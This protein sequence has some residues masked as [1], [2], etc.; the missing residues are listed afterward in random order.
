MASQSSPDQKEGR[1]GK[2]T[3]KLLDPHR[4]IP[5]VVGGILS[6]LVLVLPPVGNPQLHLG[7]KAAVKVITAVSVF[8]VTALL[9]SERRTALRVIMRSVILGLALVVLISAGTWFSATRSAF[10]LHREVSVWPKT[11]DERFLQERTLTTGGTNTNGSGNATTGG[12][13]LTI[14]LRSTHV[15]NQQYFRYTAGAPG[16]EYYLETRMRR[17]YGPVGSGCFLAL[18][19]LD[20]DRY[21]L[22]T[23]TDDAKPG[24]ALHSAR[25]DQEVQA[26]PAVEKPV[27]HTD[28][29]PYVKY[30][31]LLYPPR[32]DN[33]WTRLAVHRIGDSYD[34]FV[35][36]RLVSHTTG[37]PIPNEQVTVGAYDPGTLDGS[38]VGCQFRYLLAWSH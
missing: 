19:V 28:R 16:H 11:V 17:Q 24:V 32:A 4:L 27:D 21:F 9:A 1:I 23:V 6:L 10:A 37:I 33:S 31:S 8:V 3:T 35:N 13:L 36:D 5:G 12:G 25:I 30:W 22:F 18:G 15:A 29:L 26:D 14:R 38:Y 2:L 7:E 34:F 20:S